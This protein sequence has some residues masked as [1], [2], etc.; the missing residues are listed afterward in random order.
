MDDTSGYSIDMT[1]N[2]TDYE[3]LIIEALHKIK[4]PAIMRYI[5]II[6]LDILSE[7]KDK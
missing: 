6:V 3:Q 2:A 7:R 4:N 1:I 5:Y